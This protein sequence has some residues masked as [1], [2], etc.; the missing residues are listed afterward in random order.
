MSSTSRSRF[1]LVGRATGED[2]TQSDRQ[3]DMVEE[4]SR[5]SC[6]SASVREGVSVLAILIL[7]LVIVNRK[8]L[9]L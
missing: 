2:E 7:P 3:G 8:R 1:S 6:S 4:S 5:G 9:G